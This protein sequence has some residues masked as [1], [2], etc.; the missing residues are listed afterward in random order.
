MSRRTEPRPDLR[1]AW[2]GLSGKMHVTP[3][4]SAQ[5]KDWAPRETRNGGIR[6]TDGEG[7]HGATTVRIPPTQKR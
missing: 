4:R 6:L 7:L 2:D 1:T 5:T 3:A